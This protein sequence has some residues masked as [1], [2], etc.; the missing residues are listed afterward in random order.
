M[1]EF[2]EQFTFPSIFLKSQK[3]LFSLSM[4]PHFFTVPLH[5][6]SN[7]YIPQDTETIKELNVL[8]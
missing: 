5:C 8:G 3:S 2:L 6:L 1:P 4:G 7:V